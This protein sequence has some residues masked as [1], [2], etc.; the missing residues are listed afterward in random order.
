[1]IHHGNKLIIVNLVRREN[2]FVEEFF[3]RKFSLEWSRRLINIVCNNA[4]VWAVDDRGCVHFRH[5]HMSASQHIDSNEIAFLPPAWIMVPGE[6]KRYRSF[7]QV[8]CGPDDW[9]VID[10]ERGIRLYTQ[11]FYRSML[12]IINKMFI[13]AKVSTKKIWLEPHGK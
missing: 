2:F 5:G 11:S 1:M 3:E 12:L 7:S 8:F 6:A 13:R 10:C 4:G 9:M